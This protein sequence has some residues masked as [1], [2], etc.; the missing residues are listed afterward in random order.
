MSTRRRHDVGVT[1]CGA[2]GNTAREDSESNPAIQLIYDLCMYG[3]NVDYTVI[4]EGI[5]SNKNTARCSPA[6]G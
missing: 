3:N 1:G 6:A 2:P 5:L 4:L